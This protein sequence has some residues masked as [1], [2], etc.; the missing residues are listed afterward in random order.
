MPLPE[1]YTPTLEPD[2]YRCQLIPWPAEGVEYVTGLR[3]QPDQRAIVHHV[4]VFLAG[5]EQVAQYQAYDDVE[6]G[7]EPATTDL[8]PN[9]FP[10]T[11]RPVTSSS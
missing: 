1:A 9:R 5:P 11:S 2:D 3:V 7:P 6:E 10:S 8:S 4:I